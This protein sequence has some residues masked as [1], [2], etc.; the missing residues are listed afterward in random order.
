[1]GAWLVERGAGAVEERPA[2]T[3][4]T[5]L[6]YGTDRAALAVLASDL[7][8]V[9]ETG[10]SVRLRRAPRA[11]A[12]WE[13][14]WTAHLECV[15]LTPHIDL[16]P[17]KASARPRDWL[18]AA[19]D[20]PLIRLQA[21]MTF[22]FGEH[23]TTRLAARAVERLCLAGAKTVLDVGSGSGVLAIV[24]AMSGARS[25]LGVDVDRKAVVMARKNAKTNHVD[26]RCRFETTPVERV[27]GHFDVVVANIGL[28]VLRALGEAL[29][30]AV[31]LSG[32]LVLA[33]FLDED[34]A[35]LTGVFRGFG[36]RARSARPRQSEEGWALLVLTRHRPR[37]S[38]RIRKVPKRARS[39]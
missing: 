28:R 24:A 15:E 9:F 14:A 7:R 26:A 18:S 2:E 37:S 23:P 20:R 33:G 27:R 34:R 8:G 22:G 1:L 30:R 31:T 4:A 39:T 10:E 3:G 16:L 38:S 25:V 5:L 36:F 19:G 17:V 35:E 13:S 29:S 21:A 32:T 12:G 6:V 11:V